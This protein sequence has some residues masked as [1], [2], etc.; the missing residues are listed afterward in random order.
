MGETYD[1]PS[2]E[3]FTTEKERFLNEYDLNKDGFLEGNELRLWL[4]PDMKQT[5]FQEAKHLILIAD[6]DKVILFFSENLL[7]GAKDLKF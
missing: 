5:A 1:Q 3:W 4:I 6:E 7:K 2:S